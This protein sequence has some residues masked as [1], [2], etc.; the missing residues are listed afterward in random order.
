MLESAGITTNWSLLQIADAFE[1][2]TQ[3]GR[4]RPVG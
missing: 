1:Q 3:H 4:K 2:A